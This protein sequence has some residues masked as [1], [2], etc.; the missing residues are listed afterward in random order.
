MSD[1]LRSAFDHEWRLAIAARR[2]GNLETA[3]HHL[4][5]AHILGQRHTWLH[6][7][8]HLGMLAIGCQRR[9]GREV[10]GQLTRIVAA[11]LFSRIW[12]PL[13]NTGGA[14]VSATRPMPVPEDLRELLAS[15]EPAT[16]PPIQS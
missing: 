14:K 9:D 6:V 16:R 10:V 7:R 4:E 8:S 5:R 2:S 12:V 13:G 3:F 11:A 1:P 15:Q